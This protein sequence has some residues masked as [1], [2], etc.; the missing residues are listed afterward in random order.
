MYT[1]MCVY[2]CVC[3]CVTL[4]FSEGIPGE[5]P[6]SA[7]YLYEDNNSI[8]MAT[9]LSSLYLSFFIHEVGIK[10]VTTSLGCCED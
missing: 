10:G 8:S 6:D 9:D 1:C 4:A 2:V 3:M 5:N 7:S